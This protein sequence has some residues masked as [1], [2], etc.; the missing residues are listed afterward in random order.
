MKSWQKCL[1]RWGNSTLI[2][3]NDD[4]FHLNVSSISNWP[5]KL[6]VNVCSE[7][8]PGDFFLTLQAERTASVPRWIFKRGFA[9]GTNLIFIALVALMDHCSFIRIALCQFSRSLDI[10]PFKRMS[11]RKINYNRIMGVRGKNSGRRSRI[12]SLL[13]VGLRRSNGVIHGRIIRPRSR[14]ATRCCRNV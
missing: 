2:F 7:D 4:H 9:R 5:I 6:P 8:H 14:N 13:G 1:G 10:T 3:R 12:D 11:K